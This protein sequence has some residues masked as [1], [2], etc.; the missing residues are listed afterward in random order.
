MSR[1]IIC[2]TLCTCLVLN[3]VIITHAIASP[4]LSDH[5]DE[6]RPTSAPDKHVAF[7]P[8]IEPEKLGGEQANPKKEDVDLIAFERDLY[9]RVQTNPT[10]IRSLQDYC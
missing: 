3:V 10:D 2:H 7:M 8:K 4:R 5:L 9:A 1:R 6:Y